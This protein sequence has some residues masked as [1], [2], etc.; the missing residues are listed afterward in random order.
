MSGHFSL[1]LFFSFFVFFFWLQGMW[2]LSSLTRDR[3]HTPC[4]GKWSLNYWTARE[5]PHGFFGTSP[6][7]SFLTF[8]A[9]LPLPQPITEDFYFSSGWLFPAHSAL[10]IWWYSQFLSG[11]SV[12]TLGSFLGQDLRWPQIIALLLISLHLVQWKLSCSH[13]LLFPLIPAT[14]LQ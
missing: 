4:I 5:V 12:L 9:S 2:D 10:E 6:S 1:F 7:S 3:T 13:C 11:E 14:L 8:P